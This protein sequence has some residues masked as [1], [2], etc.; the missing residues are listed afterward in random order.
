MILTLTQ[1]IKAI[2][3]GSS[4]QTVKDSINKGDMT[5]LLYPNE[6][7][8][9]I[10]DKLTIHRINIRQS[11]QWSGDNFGTGRNHTQGRYFDALRKYIFC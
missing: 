11:N 5:A 7:L 8:H 1:L 2:E 10:L 3:P 4:P 9:E 6:T